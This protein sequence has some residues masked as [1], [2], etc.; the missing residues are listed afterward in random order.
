MKH[1]SQLNNFVTHTI[2][3]RHIVVL[4]EYQ[5]IL[6]EINIMKK[7]LIIICFLGL[8][9]GTM[10]NAQTTTTDPR[11][12]LTF[13]IKAGFNYSNVWDEQGQDFTADAKVGFVG[14]AFIG[15]PIGEFIGVQPE[16][17]LSQKGFQGSGTFAGAP[18]SFTRTTTYIDIPL[19]FQVKPSEYFTVLGGPH[20]SYL[21]N[22]KY[23]FTSS[24][25]SYSQE[26]AFDADNIRRNIFGFT[27][28]ADIYIDHVVVSARLGWD[29]Q[30]NN[31]DGTSTTP[32]YKN[33]WLQLTG[34]FKF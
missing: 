34:G 25:Y 22:D 33:Q 18:Y 27:L 6:K 10:L 3:N 13:G 19:Q 5:S 8:S 7:L 23:S 12:N 9:L 26:Q 28:G 16:M 4:M 21:I 30:A 15:I 29:L 11:T 1:G 17:L 24:Q 14:G 32:R 2:V 20:Y 31:G